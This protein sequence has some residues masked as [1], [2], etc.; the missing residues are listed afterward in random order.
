MENQNQTKRKFYKRW[1][2]WLAVAIVIVSTAGLRERHTV[3]QNNTKV[4][5][6]QNTEKEQKLIQILNKTLREES[7]S[8]EE[9]AKIQAE[10]QKDKLDQQ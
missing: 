7:L 5:R 3:P 2:F 9:K 10:E 4:T 6:R 8:V 1:W